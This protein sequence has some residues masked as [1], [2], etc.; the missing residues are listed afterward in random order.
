MTVL[1][2]A[3]YHHPLPRKVFANTES[4]SARR[5]AVS[6]GG[7][8]TLRFRALEVGSRSIHGCAGAA[9]SSAATRAETNWTPTRIKACQ[10]STSVHGDISGVSGSI[11]VTLSALRGECS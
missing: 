1:S 2:A 10:G 8:G 5:R 7:S 11:L 6:G 3:T 4:A 9:G